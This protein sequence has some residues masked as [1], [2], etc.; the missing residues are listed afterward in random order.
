[1][2]RRSSDKS[3]G[4]DLERPSTA[5]ASLKAPSP[6]ASG[7]Q[8]R[9]RNF[10]NRKVKRRHTEAQF[11]KT[12]ENEEEENDPKSPYKSKTIIQPRA[13]VSQALFMLLMDAREQYLALISKRRKADSTLGTRLTII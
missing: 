4:D 12:K 5:K 3:Q 10:Q 8:K 6:P 1:M 13:R 9:A 7:K 2:K 11:N